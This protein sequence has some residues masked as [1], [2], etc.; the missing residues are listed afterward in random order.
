LFLITQH[1]LIAGDPKLS[2]YA[3]SPTSTLFKNV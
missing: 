3:T 1:A 2:S